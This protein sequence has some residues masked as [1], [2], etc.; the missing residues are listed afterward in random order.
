MAAI[1]IAQHKR[2]VLVLRVL[3]LAPGYEP[4]LTLFSVV[5]RQTNRKT[6]DP[7][8]VLV[9]R[10]P[11]NLNISHSKDEHKHAGDILGRD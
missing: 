2:G 3:N 8:R 7:Q 11:S 6:P 5:R 4:V 1:H 9:F 10:S